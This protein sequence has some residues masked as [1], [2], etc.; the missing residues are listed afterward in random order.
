MCVGGFYIGGR[1]ASYL[2]GL[3][4]RLVV[5]FVL[6]GFVYHDIVYTFYVMLL[7][8]AHAVGAPGCVCHSLTGLHMEFVIAV[9][10]W[11]C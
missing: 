1:Y 4:W 2:F 10:G 5:R 9:Y 8:I 11:I 3:G 6:T 7:D